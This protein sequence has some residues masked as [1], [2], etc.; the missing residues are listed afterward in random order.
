MSKRILFLLTLAMGCKSAARVEPTD[1]STTP[2][3]LKARARYNAAAARLD[4]PVYWY[5]DDDGRIEPNEVAIL[6]GVGAKRSD[7]VTEDGFTERFQAVLA[8]IDGG[9]EAPAD[10]RRA[11]VVRELA[12]SRPTL[13]RTDLRDAP[14]ADKAFVRAMLEVGVLIERLFAR[15]NGVLGMDAKIPADDPAS[16]VLFHRNQGPWCAAASTENDPACSALDP[17]PPKI[18]GLYPAALQTSDAK[19]CDTLAARPDGEALMHQFVAVREKDS[20]LVAVPYSEAFAEDMNAVADRLERAA[21]G[22]GPEE[23]ALVAYLEAAAKAFRSNRWEPA[24]EAWAAMNATNSKWYLRVGPDETYFE[25]CRRK[26]GFH[27]TFARIDPSARAWQDRLDP[28]KNEMEASLAKLAGAPYSAREVAFD[29][30]DFIHIVLNAGDARRPFS[31]TVGQSLPNWGPVAN[32]GRGRTVAM[33][34]VL[35]A[36]ESVAANERQARSILCP[37]TAK[38]FDPDP[39]ALTM[40]TVLHEAAHN[41]GPSH[42]YAVDGKVDDEVFGGANAS[43]FEELKAETASYYFADWLAA[44]GLITKERASQ[45]HVRDLIWGFGHVARGLDDADGNPKTYSYVAAIQTGF[46]LDHGVATWNADELAAN[47]EDRGCLELDLAKM[48]DAIETLMGKVAGI[49]ARGD[50]KGAEALIESY[51]KSPKGALLDVVQARWRREP[52]ASLVYG[53]QL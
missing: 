36:P 20:E 27:M 51:V 41:L 18:S 2:D 38:V 30:P 33:M 14:E 31:A 52:E 12:S 45:A 37:A 6:A 3:M 39:D 35:T 40:S 46:W 21:H 32:E 42:E 48:G 29:L 34:N 4:V 22:L 5:D 28:V 10:A 7:W 53:V 23:A 26:A 19:F 13:V 17:K 50:A 8:R 16:R 43:V 25:P 9:L 24:D 15:Q 49:K 44:K 47:G 1:P 11:A